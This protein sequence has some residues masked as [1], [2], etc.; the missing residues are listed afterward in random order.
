MPSVFNVSKMMCHNCSVVYEDKEIMTGFTIKSI[1]AEQY[2]PP[3][4]HRIYTFEATCNSMEY[5]PISL[6]NPAPMQFILKGDGEDIPFYIDSYQRV[7]S[8]ISNDNYNSDF[9]FTD[10]EFT[11]YGHF[12]SRDFEEKSNKSSGYKKKESKPILNRWEILDL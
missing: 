6:P 11:I 10:S 5:P 1:D 2:I 4:N 8:I 7:C 9:S 12:D 3:Y